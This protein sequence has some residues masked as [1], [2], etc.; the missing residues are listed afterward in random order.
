MQN[1]LPI[2]LAQGATWI[3]TITFLDEDENPVDLTG[4][5]ALME[6]RNTVESTGSPIIT[7]GTSTNTISING[8][9]GEITITISSTITAALTSGTTL[10]YD[11]FIYSSTGV[12]TRLLKG[13]AYVSGSVTR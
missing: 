9:N 3:R 10:Y 4:Y 5:T 2:E 12:A 13:T 8:T 1:Q 11:L 6:F 7:V